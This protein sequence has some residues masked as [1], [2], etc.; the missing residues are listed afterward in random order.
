MN[1]FDHTDPSSIARARK[2]AEGVFV[3][4]LCVL[5]AVLFDAEREAVV[6]EREVWE[7]G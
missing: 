3:S 4:V 5:R 7:G 6:R 1:T 2:V